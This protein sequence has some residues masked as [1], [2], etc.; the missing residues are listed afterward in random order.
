[1]SDKLWYYSVGQERKGP[2]SEATLAALVAAD[3]IKADAKVWSEGMA[4]WEPA[5]RHIPGVVPPA[6]V[7]QGSRPMSR[8][9]AAANP[10]R[11]YFPQV[12]M[13]EAFSR[14]FS[15]YAT[16]SGRSS[17][18]EYW[19]F[20]LAGLIISVVLIIIDLSAFGPYAQFQ[21]FSSLWSLAVLLP[22][23]A[24]GARRLHDINKSGW[25]LLISLVPLLGV[26]LLL[27]WFCQPGDD[28]PNDFG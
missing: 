7:M 21:P 22:N 26:I 16:F 4:D 10:G 23:L 8:P 13:V 18:A 6:P 17:R 14:A 19:W 28:R 12:G 1:M 27:V 15:N 3:A 2:V 5:F 24:I 11:D 9:G 20:V 25:W